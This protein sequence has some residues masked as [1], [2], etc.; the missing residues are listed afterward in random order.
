MNLTH[1]FKLFSEQLKFEVAYGL[2][3]KPEAY[4]QKASIQGLWNYVTPKKR[5]VETEIDGEGMFKMKL[6]S[7][8]AVDLEIQY[9]FNW[10]K[11]TVPNEI[12]TSEQNVNKQKMEVKELQAKD[13]I[14]S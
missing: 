4:K 6:Y 7:T 10:F 9:I 11:V 14:P 5:L 3:L 8:R 1:K 13:V 2:D 12:T